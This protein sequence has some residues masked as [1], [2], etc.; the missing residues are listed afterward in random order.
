MKLTV[1]SHAIDITIEKEETAAWSSRPGHAWPA[2]SISGKKVYAEFDRN[3][4]SMIEINGKELS[5]GSTINDPDVHEFNS[6]IADVLK[7]ML[8]PLHECYRVAVG[9]F[10]DVTPFQN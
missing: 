3:G 2:S 5:C 9:Q 7:G 10:D 1:Y 4:L 6:L 8:S